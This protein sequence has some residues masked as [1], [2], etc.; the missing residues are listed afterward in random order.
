[1]AMVCFYQVHC[2]L[3]T[4]DGYLTI[5]LVDPLDNAN[6]TEE[7]KHG[8]QDETRQLVVRLTVAAFCVKQL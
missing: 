5:T 3:T 6:N 8:S 7:K 4:E 1:M 2:N